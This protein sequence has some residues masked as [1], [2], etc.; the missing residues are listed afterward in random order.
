[1]KFEKISVQIFSGASNP[2]AL[3]CLSRST[4][5][6]FSSSYLLL[7]VIYLCIQFVSSRPSSILFLYN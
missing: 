7:P 1:M 4:F 6:I 3:F 5:F 2:F